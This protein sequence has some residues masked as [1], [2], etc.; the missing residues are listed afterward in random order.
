MSEIRNLTRNGET[1]YPL[2][3]VDGVLGRN[4]VPL[5]EVN[6]I[7]DVSEYNASGDPLIYPQYNTLSLALESIPQER[8][9][10]GMTIRYIDSTNGEYVQYRYLSTS[11]ANTDFINTS[12]WQGVDSELK[13]GSRNLAESGGVIGN[14][15]CR[16]G[17][18]IRDGI[19]G[20]TATEGAVITDY[21]DI[22]NLDVI[23]LNGRSSDVVSAYAFY[24]DN[25]IYIEGTAVGGTE[26]NRKNITILKNEFPVNAKY[27]VVN[28]GNSTDSFCGISLSSIGRDVTKLR[29]EILGKIK[30]DFDDA[31]NS[32]IPTTKA[33][34]DYT[35]Q[36]AGV[37]DVPSMV[38]TRGDIKSQDILVLEK[39]DN[40]TFFVDSYSY[41]EPCVDEL[42]ILTGETK[43]SFKYFNGYLYVSPITGS[44]EYAW[45]VVV[46]AHTVKNNEITELKVTTAGTN[47]DYT[48][49]DTVGYV[50]FKDIATFKEH[51]VGGTTKTLVDGVATNINNSPK[52]SLYIGYYHSPYIYGGKMYL[53]YTLE[54]PSITELQLRLDGLDV[55][56]LDTETLVLE[57]DSVKM[58]ETLI[59][60]KPDVNY[61]LDTFSY[62]EPCIDEL[63]IVPGNTNIVFKYYS[64]RL[65]V[66]P[67]SGTNYKWQAVRNASSLV[68]GKV[69][70]L[71]VTEAGTDDNYAVGDTVGY[72]IFKDVESFIEHPYASNDVTVSSSVV[73]DINN[74]PKIK[75]ELGGHDFPV[76]T[77]TTLNLPY[78]LKNPT[79]DGL[80]E[81]LEEAESKIENIKVNTLNVLFIGNSYTANSVSY[82]PFIL[83]N[84]C[85]DLKFK[86]GVLF[87]DG[88]TLAEHLAN[89]LNEDVVDEGGT[90]QSP[91]NYNRY[92]YIT[93]DKNS[94]SHIAT[95][96]TIFTGLDDANWDIVS[97]HQANRYAGGEWAT[98]Y[99]PYIYRLHK[100]I[101]DYLS[102]PFKFGFDIIHGSNTG[103]YEG[104]KSKFLSIAANAQT[105]EEDTC[106][107]VIF[108]YGTAVE[109][110]RTIASMQLLGDGSYHNLLKDS[111]HLQSGIGQLAAS[112]AIAIK[113][114]EQVGCISK[115]ISE[116]TFPTTEWVNSI[117]TIR[118]A[119]VG[120]GSIG[121][122]ED[123]CFLAQVAAIQAVKKPYVVTDINEYDINGD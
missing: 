1:F 114:A 84:I 23:K 118:V 7:F 105:L 8:R 87:L 29:D 25:K 56:Q 70:E 72:V 99:A 110:L 11:I 66:R 73:T 42:Y 36:T 92:S 93:D 33:V 109:N 123:N 55:G 41:Y 64:N 82:V 102:R 59:L 81:R 120:T 62:Y 50:I 15:F 78:N 106:T 24:D 86:I 119:D 103:T 54:N 10:G 79:T 101:A 67:K 95:N 80:Q 76:I 57:R 115:I 77:D 32:H 122:T 27:I 13:A 51:S 20:I 6:G 116:G 21:I 47:E 45:K 61:F 63:Y 3:H 26:N 85:P 35:D 16:N 94:W 28:G 44:S 117:S 68:D 17:L 113:L 104:D 19:I 43:I 46:G 14:V 12:N 37:L 98:N 58:Q 97:T 88:G 96:V 60:E 90:T 89:I 34:K 40:V 112:Y 5:G 121:V 71:K 38:L 83:K 22:T 74:S 52:I 2:T 49:G 9:K 39:P 31:D 30:S 100:A 18:T 107:E 4:G 69:I 48:V 111:S 91:Q 53:P 75:Y 108:P 65:F